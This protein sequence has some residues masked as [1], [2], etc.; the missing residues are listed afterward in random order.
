MD[1]YLH[2]HNSISSIC[3]LDNMYSNLHLINVHSIY[4]YNNFIN[5]SSQLGNNLFYYTS[6]N[7]III[8]DGIYSLLS[9]NKYLQS[10]VAT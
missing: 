5:I 1:S 8:P 2:S 4:F 7:S 3:N 9:F 6:S 10:M